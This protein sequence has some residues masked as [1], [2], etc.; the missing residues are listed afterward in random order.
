VDKKKRAKA[1]VDTLREK[2]Q[3]TLDMYCL[4]TAPGF[5]IMVAATLHK[6]GCFTAIVAK[7][8]PRFLC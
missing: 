7:L 2:G 4:S 1:S 8:T 6:G 3:G 5:M